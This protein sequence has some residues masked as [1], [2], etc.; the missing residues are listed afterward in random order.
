MALLADLRSNPPTLATWERE[1]TDMEAASVV[2]V[3][4]HWVAVRGNGFAIRLP[5]AR[6]SGSKMRLGGESGCS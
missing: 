1:R 5:T 3:T 4:G 6:Q 2:M